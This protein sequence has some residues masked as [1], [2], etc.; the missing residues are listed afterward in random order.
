LDMYDYHPDKIRVSINDNDLTVQVEQ[1]NFYRQI[2]LPS[3]ID[4]SSLSVHYHYD[5][6]LYITIKLLDE[7]SSFK[8]I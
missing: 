7:Y 2:T 6:K 1:T 8:Y 5:R 3:N 4:L